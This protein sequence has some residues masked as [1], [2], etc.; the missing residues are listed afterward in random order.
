MSQMD[1]IDPDE[2]VSGYVEVLAGEKDPLLGEREEIEKKKEKWFGGYEVYIA[3]DMSGSM[4][5][6]LNGV[7]KSMPNATWCSYSS[8]PS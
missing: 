4:D 1:E 6:T 5:E 8:I 3:A 2:L 7:K